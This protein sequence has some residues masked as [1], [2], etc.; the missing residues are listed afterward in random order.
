MLKYIATLHQKIGIPYCALSEAIYGRH[1]M[2]CEE[3]L[4]KKPII[5]PKFQIE[6]QSKLTLLKQLSFVQAVLYLLQFFFNFTGDRVAIEP[7]YP[8]KNDEFCKSGRYNLSEV[9][10]CATPPDHGNL[11]RF[12]THRADFCYK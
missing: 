9:F 11:S 4:Q 3:R 7:G 8:L 12:Y 10:F 2:I 5:D 1:R 6:V